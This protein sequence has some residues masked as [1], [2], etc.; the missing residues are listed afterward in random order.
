MK[1]LISIKKDEDNLNEAFKK[2]EPD[3]NYISFG[4][5]E[6]LCVN[7]LRDAMDDEADWIG[8]WLYDLEFGTKAK[9]TSVKKDGKNVPIKTLSNLYD[10]IV[11][12]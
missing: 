5:Y 12:K 8:Y 2:F 9:K 1:E 6:N 11:N 4:S 10:C 7:T 3:F